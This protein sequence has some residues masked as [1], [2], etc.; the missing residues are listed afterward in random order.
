MSAGT[1]PLGASYMRLWI[2]SVVSNFGDGLATV[3][4]PWLASSIT[5]NPLHLAGIAI[6]TRIPWALFTLPAGVITDRVDRRK[7]IALMDSLRFALT[8]A[9]A[10]IVGLGASQFPDPA[11]LADA[12]ASAPSNAALYLA[13]LYVSAL[14][15][16]MAEVLRDNAAQTLMPAMVAPDQ[17]EKANGRLW[18]AEMVMNSFVGPP[19]AGLLIAVAFALPFYV[20][21]ATF[22]VSAVL[23][24]AIV[25]DFRPQGTVAANGP[26][27]KI[28]WVGEIKE[29]VSWLWQNRLLRSLAIILGTLNAMFTVAFTTYVFF[30]QEILGLTASQFGLLMTAGAFGG[31]LGSVVAS[32][33]SVKL[34]SGTSLFVSIIM[35]MLQFL[36]T[37]LTSSALVAWIAFFVGTLWGVV[38][39]VITVSLRQQIIPDEL[40]G[41]VNSVYRFFAWGMMPIGSL[42][43]GA[44]VAITE[45]VASRELALRVPF[46]FAA[47]VMVVIFFVAL[48]RLN[49]AQM[50]AARTAG[51][52]QSGPSE[53]SG[54]D[55]P[56]EVD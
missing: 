53:S 26:G 19:A 17:L 6:A 37:G 14:L 21:A 2:A 49:T 32:K 28:N 22:L 44:I 23:I 50:E 38:W 36:V 18:G 45:G 31:V 34:G 16:G 55:E 29:G 43:G 25:G 10:I 42:L 46:F 54:S 12:S 27:A 4:Y 30:A 5:R 35:M 3:A 20:D 47:A 9:V 41:R 39:N 52:N 48:P 13:V 56:S 33:I 11:D 8:L 40:L 1:K 7:L 24:F 51:Q 15:L